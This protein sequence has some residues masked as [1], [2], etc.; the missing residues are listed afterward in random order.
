MSLSFRMIAAMGILMLVAA[1]CGREKGT[2]GKAGSEKVE[3]SAASTSKG[4]TTRSKTT[5]P[6]SKG[7]SGGEAKAGK[8]VST[9]TA[10]DDGGSFDLRQGQVL[11]V[12]LAA[13]HGTGLAWVMVEPSGTVLVREGT[14]VYVAKKGGS[15]TETWHFK[16]VRAG[17]QTVRLEY[18]RKWSQSVPDRTFRFTATVR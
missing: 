11:S 2:V 6:A 15:G 14:P 12:V 17:R 7:E 16:A 18:R 9:L 4:T 8:R 13:N 5:R 10:A 3:A 1:G